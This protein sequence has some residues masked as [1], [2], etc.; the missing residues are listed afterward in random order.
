MRRKKENRP[1][2]D[3]NRDYVAE[4]EARKE[5]SNPFNSEVIAKEKQ[6]M[7]TLRK[8]YLTYKDAEL[9]YSLQHKKLLE[10]GDACG[11]LY[12]DGN[13]VRINRDIFDAYL[14]NFHQPAGM[15]QTNG[16]REKKKLEERQG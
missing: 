3:E 2:F 11:A 12:R 14:E 6:V 15:Y 4:A 1:Y 8:Q 7:L 16:N 10:L 13:T 9:V 5:K